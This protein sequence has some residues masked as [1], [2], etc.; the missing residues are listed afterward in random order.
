MDIPQDE[1]N[2]WI[3]TVRE[4]NRMAGAGELETGRARLLAGLARAGERTQSGERWGPALTERYEAA[5]AEFK[6]DWG[7]ST[8]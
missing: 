7:W 4:A 3:D 2:R 8:V 1:L 6:L 5:I